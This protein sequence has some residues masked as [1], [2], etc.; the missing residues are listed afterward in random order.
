MKNKLTIPLILFIFL[1]SGFQIASAEQRIVELEKCPCSSDIESRNKTILENAVRSDVILQLPEGNFSSES[2]GMS[3]VN[4]FTLKGSVDADGNSTTK[5][6]ILKA[7]GLSI[8]KVTNM[9]LENLQI[10]GNANSNL[11]VLAEGGDVSASNLLLTVGA[12]G[13]YT[14]CLKMDLDWLVPVIS[15]ILF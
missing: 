4:N 12:P 6:K 11:V 7:T 14:D 5:L 8:S 15:L 13:T 3:G 2:L 1:F 10:E 9:R